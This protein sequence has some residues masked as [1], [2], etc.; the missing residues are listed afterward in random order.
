MTK[1]LTAEGVKHA[2]SSTIRVEIPDG[3]LPGLYLVIQ[4]SGV[5]SWAARY[6]FEGKPS[7]YTIGRY[8]ALSLAAARERG[9]DVFRKVAEGRN[10][11]AEKAKAKLAAKMPVRVP[12]SKIVEFES[13]VNDFV[14]RYAR[15][16]TRDWQNTQ[17]LL[18]RHF[19]PHWKGVRIADIAKSDIIDVLDGMVEAGMGPGVDR[20]FGQLRK[21]FNWL[22]DNN[23]LASSPCTGIGR[24]FD[25]TS[26]DRVL[27]DEEIYI[28]R[29]AADRT[30]YPFG[31]L[32]MLLLL[33]GQRLNEVAGAR[34]AEFDEEYSSW[35]IPGSRTK[36]RKTHD[37]VLPR[38]ATEIM[39]ALPRMPYETTV[40]GVSKTIEAEYLFTTIGR[41][42]VFRFLQGQVASQRQDD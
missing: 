20:A 23:R 38:Q 41:A 14:E 34:W 36:N 1:G 22:V 6:R 18:A 19:V 21:M 42:P 17:R 25:P 31:P 24:R 30:D 8:P 16:R 27:T 13:V 28:Y 37:L 9:Q 32:F 3:H 26:R 15:A 39:G 33:T 5:K 35:T 29:V 2:K 11:A 10:P 7:K 12:K 40:D 4:P